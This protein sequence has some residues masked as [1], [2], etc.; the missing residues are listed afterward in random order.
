MKGL[1]SGGGR[2]AA[3][4]SL[5][6]KGLRRARLM[7]AIE[8][9]TV[10][11]E[12][13]ISSTIPRRAVGPDLQDDRH[14]PFTT[15]QQLTQTGHDLGQRKRLV[16]SSGLMHS[17]ALATRTSER[18]NLHTVHGSEDVLVPVDRI[19]ERNLATITLV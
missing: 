9:L 10:K 18:L 11:K 14:S 6:T 16:Q 8:S 19:Q 7:T 2:P 1:R 15:Q 5:L 3:P 4:K 13:A 17:D 12:A